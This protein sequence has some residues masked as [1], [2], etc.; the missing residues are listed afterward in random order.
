LAYIIYTS[1]TTGQ[2]KAVMVEHRG[3][4]RLVAN[5]GYI[6]FSRYQR[7]LQTGTL[8]FDASTFE[9]WGA[10]VNGLTL[11]QVKKEDI[12]FVDNMKE[13]VSRYGIEVLWMTSALFNH[14]FQEDPGIFKG[15]KHLLV[16]GDVVSP[17]Q[18]NRLRGEY[19]AI[20]VTNGYGPT[21]NTTFST[22]LSV[23]REYSDKIPIGKPIANSTAYIMDKS[24]HLCPIGVPG[25]LLVG[26]DGLSRG[27]LNNPELTAE[28]F[29]KTSRQLADNSL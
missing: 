2:P 3:V 25:E 13:K 27:Y 21:E 29:I 12:L 5:T 19:P 22:S 7:L 24:F 9:I 15:I 6:D 28:R 1:G 14:H 4:V 18:V 20:K 17:T 23:E 11:Y 10:L 26:G 16:G 8:S